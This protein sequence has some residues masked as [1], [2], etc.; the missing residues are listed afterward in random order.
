MRV[1][2]AYAGSLAGSA[3]IA[4]LRETRHLDV[5]AV[6]LDLGQGR[7][8]EAVRDRALA[9]GARRAHVL[10]AREEFGRRFVLPALLA[11]AMHAGT[12]P[13]SLALSRP[14]IAEKLVE[15]AAVERADAVAHAGLAG[16]ASRLHRLLRSIAPATA[17]L[18]PVQEWRLS[19]DDL[20]AF[21]R[22]H[23]LLAGPTLAARGEVTFWGRSR[24]CD[25]AEAGKAVASFFT[26]VRPA[27]DCPSEAA[28]VDIAFERGVPTSLNGIAL[29]LIELVAALNTLAS[30]HGVG[31]AVH[32]GLLCD[33]PA[34]VLLHASHRAL[35]RAAAAPDVLRLGDILGAEYASLI[36]E[37]RWFSPLRPALDAFVQAAQAPVSGC[38]RLSLFRGTHETIGVE[39]S[40]PPRTSA[41]VTPLLSRKH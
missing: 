22:R 19:A 40:Q 5:V 29:P 11:D 27:A 20:A 31:R 3:A 1:V 6:T 16:E 4:W 34:A 33:A 2:L 30:T 26:G 12:V 38:V 18:A 24:S 14:I 15:M 23:G 25:P 37:G 8:L 35:T 36:D 9:L 10:D 41:A 7:Q 39:L 13:M 21:G 32:E 28:S 17:I